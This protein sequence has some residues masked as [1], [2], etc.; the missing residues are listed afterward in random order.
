MFALM[1]NSLHNCP[2]ANDLH[3]FLNFQPAMGL[4]ACTWF[5]EIVFQKTCVHL[6]ACMYARIYV[7]VF[8]LSFCTHMSIVAYAKSL[9]NEGC[10]E[11]V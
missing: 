8:C 11:P 2:I 9:R 4:W 3:R 7:G 1:S 10:T 6:Y 5:T